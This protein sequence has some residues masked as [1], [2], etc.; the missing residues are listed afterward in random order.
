ML[1]DGSSTELSI[2]VGMVIKLPDRQICILIKLDFTCTNNQAEYEAMF[3]G[4]KILLEMKTRNISVHGDLWLVLRKVTG[5]YKCHS[6]TL[7]LYFAIVVQILDKFDQ[8]L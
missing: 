3:I 8:D 4:L 6:L 1:F 5:E 2:E 7:A